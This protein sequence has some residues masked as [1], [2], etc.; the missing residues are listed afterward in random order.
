MARL[1][2]QPRAAVLIKRLKALEGRIENPEP[3]LESVG[4]TLRKTTVSRFFSQ[5]SPTGRRWKPSKAARRE[6]RPTLIRTKRLLSSFRAV[7]SRGKLEV[8]TDVWY[9]R[10]LQSG[11]AIDATYRQRSGKA[12][13]S[14]SRLRLPSPGTTSAQKLAR[15]ALKRQRRRA[16]PRHVKLPARRFLGTSKTDRRRTTKILLAGLEE[17]L[18]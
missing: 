7:V 13:A 9:A 5:T 1:E 2:V 15:A 14:I 11:G 8:G 12:K 17:A 16:K 4:D 6:K 10:I 18:K 3:I